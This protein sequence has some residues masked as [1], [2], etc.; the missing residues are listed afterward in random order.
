MQESIIYQVYDSQRRL[1]RH[2]QRERDRRLSLLAAT[3]RR[4][5]RRIRGDRSRWWGDSLRQ[6]HVESTTQVRSHPQIIR[7]TR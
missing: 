4:R 2:E 3:T 7:T 5:G 6:R 1:E